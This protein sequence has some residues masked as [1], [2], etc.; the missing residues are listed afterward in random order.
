M[1]M[2]ISEY[3]NENHLVTE[4]IQYTLQNK[5]V[6]ASGKEC[7]LFV[8]GYEFWL[9]EGGK[10]GYTGAI[11]LLATDDRG[12]VWL[13]EA[14]QS[15]NPELSS[16]I[17]ENQIMNYRRALGRRTQEEISL[18]TRRFLLNK[19]AGGLSHPYISDGCDSLLD[20]F[21]NWAVY[22]GEGAEFGNQLYNLTLK[23]IYEE[24]VICAVM[25]DE[26]RKEVWE[27]RPIDEKPYGYIVVEG[28]GEAFHATAIVHS[29]RLEH[30]TDQHYDS[31][32]TSWTEVVNE[33]KK[34]KPTPET[35]GTFL[36]P[37]V[38]SLYRKC[39]DQLRDSGWC[40]ISKSNSKAFIVDLP[41]KYSVPIRIHLGWVDF[42]ASFSIENRLPGELGLKFNI[43]FRHFK[44]SSDKETQNVGYRLA[45]R[46]AEQARYNGR[47]KGLSIQTRELTDAEKDSWD[48]EMYRRIDHENRDY[49]GRPEEIQ[50]FEEVWRF[51][52]DILKE[53]VYS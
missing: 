20:A 23:Q 21:R 29:D 4:F 7:A 13:I 22:Q 8:W 50:D 18:K 5:L 49:L 15:G 43:D 44:N 3:A 42:D 52:R 32:A 9:P 28:T 35:V 11:D 47:G 31:R 27:G 1:E 26:F 2:I 6:L 34:V 25:A 37:Q 10:R 45:K 51:L 16:H 48:W 36:T 19:G 38:Q 40:G 17:W 41:T 53:T 33:K 14:K 24:T 30:V 46:L 39:L 12:N